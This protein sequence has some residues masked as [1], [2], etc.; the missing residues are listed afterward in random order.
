MTGLQKM[1][2]IFG[3]ME[4]LSDGKK[5]IWVWDYANDK[6]RIKS[7]MTKEEIIAS[8]KAKYIPKP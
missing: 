5:V 4:F 6:P 3:E 7:E 1:L 8:D 2:K